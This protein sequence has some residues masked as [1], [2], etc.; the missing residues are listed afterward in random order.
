M[1]CGRTT[2]DTSDFDVNDSCSDRVASP[3]SRTMD[4]A[5]QKTGGTFRQMGEDATAG[6]AE[7]VAAAEEEEQA[8]LDLT[9]EVR[10]KSE[11]DIAWAQKVAEIQMDLR[12]AKMAADAAAA[13]AAQELRDAEIEKTD[14]LLEAIRAVQGECQGTRGSGP[15]RSRRE[16]ERHS[17]RCQ[18]R[19]VGLGSGSQ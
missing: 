3:H 17:R 1:G 11:E 12:V 6:A 9:E 14:D 18:K 8:L 10:K 7:M 19:I 15:T 13:L 2:E 16:S 5:G 4:T